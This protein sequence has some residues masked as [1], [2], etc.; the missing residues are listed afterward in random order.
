MDTR[1]VRASIHP[2]I[3]IARLGNSATE[4]FIGPEVAEPSPQSP[5][6]YRDASGAL[7]REAARFRL[8]GY[9]AAGDVVAE[10]TPDTAEITW[11]VHLANRKAAWYQ[12][13]IA[14]DI[15]EAA[16]HVLPLRNASVVGRDAL[17][18]DAELQCIQ[19]RQASPV[20]CSGFFMGIPVKIGELRTDAEGR[21]VVL[22]GHGVSASPSNAPIFDDNVPND[23]INADGWYDDTADGPVTATVLIDGVAI[24]VESAWV[25]T[26]PPNYAPQIKGV[27]TMYDLLVDLFIQASW[28]QAPKTISFAKDVYPIL[29]RLTGLQWVNRGFATMFGH[30]GHFNFEDPALIARLSAL[31]AAGALDINQEFRRQIFNSFRLPTPADGNP[32]PWPW[33]YGDAME[34]DGSGGPLQNASISKTQHGILKQWVDGKFVDDWSQQAPP[35]RSIEQL[36]LTEQPA[37]LDRAALEFCL[38]DAFHPGCEMTW[39]MRHSTLFDRPFRIRHRLPGLPEPNYGPTLNQ[40]QCLAST[41]PLHAQGPGDITRWMGLPWQADTAFCRSGYDTAYDPFAPTFWPAR[42]P[43][44]VLSQQSYEI[45]IDRSQPREKRVEAFVNRT[46]WNQPLKGATAMEMQQMVRIFG[47]MGLVEVRE[48]VVD[49]PALPA[50]MMVASYGPDVPAVDSRPL[51]ALPGQQ[52]LPNGANFDSPKEANSAPRPVRLRRPQD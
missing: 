26:A 34:S 44:Q 33:I 36:P 35:P 25:V 2:A 22:A 20:A 8:Y 47:S 29:Q 10:L 27:R 46:D 16:S 45:V 28:M 4:F 48:G 5:G 31:P 51:P 18:I 23:F 11:S 50:V 6:F 3:G 52:E 14:M 30:G 24:P 15:P 13:Q 12:W 39:P 1:I 17:V 9:N 49:D 42:V 37:M 7:K 40:E 43:N 19:G 21:L 41:G 38:A 32:L